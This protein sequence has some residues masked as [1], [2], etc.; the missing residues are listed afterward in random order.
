MPLFYATADDLVPVFAAVE[1]KLDVRYT[2][3]DHQSTE[4]IESW[5]HGEE[6]PSLWRSSLSESAMT[7]PAYLVTLGDSSIKPRKI[8]QNSGKIVWAIDQLENPD[9]T[10][11]MHGGRYREDV[12]LHG[13]VAAASR[14]PI[15]LKLQRAFESAIRKHFVHIKAFRVGKAAEL[16]LDSGVRLTPSAQFP[17]EY[18]LSRQ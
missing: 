18:D 12:L 14:T 1:A 8:R 13:Q 4:L 2:F 10:V 3:V 9:S 11:F 15:A 5:R 6:L 16:L 7:G 17:M